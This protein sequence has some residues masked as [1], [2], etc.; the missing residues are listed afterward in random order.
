VCVRAVMASAS[1]P[2]MRGEAGPI[3]K[4]VHDGCR[5]VL[6]AVVGGVVSAAGTGA[7]A[8]AV[9][10]VVSALGRLCDA[11]G[12]DIQVVN[13]AWKLLSRVVAAYA[14]V[15]A[16]QQG[17]EALSGTVLCVE[18]AKWVFYCTALRDTR[19]YVAAPPA[20][21]AVTTATDAG[22]PAART[23]TV[24]AAVTAA[25]TTHTAAT[26]TTSETITAYLDATG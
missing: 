10:V 18:C 8:S 22:A 11:T 1:N 3:L 20:T 2:A 13:V 26:P 12:G 6:A 15:F 24:A 19:L 25:T 16:S 23:A 14:A 4:S 9:P 7:G 17:A 21:A 5:A